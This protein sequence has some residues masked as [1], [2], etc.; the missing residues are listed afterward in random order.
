MNYSKLLASVILKIY[1]I[2]IVVIGIV[3]I[4]FWSCN[5]QT[6]DKV[7][8]LKDGDYKLTISK[9]TF[10]FQFEDV[11]KHQN[12]PS[13]SN[14]GL[15]INGYPVVSVVQQNFK[16]KEELIVKVRTL[17]GD[18]ALVEVRFNA[19]I[20]T[21]NITPSNEKI[22]EISLQLGGMPVAHGLGDAA[23]FKEEFNIIN[24]KESIYTI[25]NDGGG[26]RW[27]STF[28][29]FPQNSFA[30]VFF[31]KGKKVVTL[32][33]DKYAM[34][35]TKAGK[36]K[37]Y[38]FLGNPKNIYKNYKK[39]RE[40][41]GY[42]DVVP[43]FRLFELG[44]ES[45]DALGWN[46]NQI[47]VQKILQKFHENDYPIRW[48]VTGSGF[49][50]QGGTTTSFG[51]WGE[52][53]PD[54]LV[55]KNWLHANDI[56]WMI[57]L[58]TNF[59]PEGGPFYPSTNKRDKNLKVN[60]FYGNEL[61]AE[62]K[63]NDFLVNDRNGEILSI[64]SGVFPIVPSYLLNG[65]APGAAEWYQKQ[66]QK[67]D[68]DGIKEDTMMKIDSL[69]GIYNAPIREIAAQ[70]GLV[71]AR[72]G[73]FSSPGTLLRINDTGVGNLDK[74][75]PINYLQYAASG[76]PNVYSDVAG[77]HNMDNL[78]DVDRNIRHTWLL[79]L[80][81]GLA[82]GKY[83]EKWPNDKLKSFK[84]A[85]DFHYQLGPYMYSAATEGYRSGYPSTLTPLTIAF[86]KDTTVVDHPNFQWMIGESILATPL[87]KNSESG[88]MDVYLPQGVW[89]DYESG[90]K[91]EG[92]LTLTD[93]Q[94]PLNKIPGFVGG[95]GVIVLRTSDNLPLMATVYPIVKKKTS[96]YFNYP[97]GVSQSMITYKKWKTAERIKL[98]NITL[99][100]EMDFTID[101][102]T[103]KISFPIEPGHNY[104]IV[105]K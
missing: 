13:A 22:N 10:Q 74:R 56:K 41:E 26:R 71:M 43:K 2:K 47:T 65:D 1:K 84:K 102:V 19:G 99:N 33:E 23:A 44:W 103:D 79:A 9:K 98:M 92:P 53:F 6:T 86:P 70:G 72:N 60:S 30:G 48:A 7:L 16:N 11:K 62:A 35:I 80:T 51:K 5:G 21:F 3:F 69:T 77:V 24:N 36:A 78:K 59:I 94:I 90:K 32:K 15:L 28:A 20:T 12:I 93:Y 67:W 8:Q 81:A 34:N 61:S 17:K 91:F 31:D 88:K 55:F 73:E 105:E 87:L 49:W 100:K 57:G 85:I 14:S 64:T 39:V 58:R 96:F 40:S 95:K 29:I 75:I 25:L 76:F 42:L 50:D 54:A 46:T 38:Y 63:K 82:V 18:E 4:S 83:P 37:F 45:W 27:A 104:S 68:I 66:Y 89:Y 97:D 101:S 52:K